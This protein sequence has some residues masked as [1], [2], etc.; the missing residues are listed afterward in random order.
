MIF[1]SVLVRPHQTFTV[2]RVL[3]SG[4]LLSTG[5]L[6]CALSQTPTSV[7]LLHADMQNAPTLP[8]VEE[9]LNLALQQL[10]EVSKSITP[11]ELKSICQR[12]GQ[13]HHTMAHLLV[14]K[15]LES[16]GVALI[17]SYAF[18]LFFTN[19]LFGQQTTL[20]LPEPKLSRWVWETPHTMAKVTPLCAMAKAAPLC[21]VAMAILL[22]DVAVEALLHI[23]GTAMRLFTNLV[24]VVPLE[25]LLSTKDQFLS[26][27]PMIFLTVHPV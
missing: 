7:L 12:L 5:I 26:S 15:T 20:V 17:G 21:A 10:L 23:T 6:C 16:E 3:R 24:A 4:P 14:M 22:H 9:Q 27:T 1:G 8:L 18:S 2:L 11:E 13:M 19:L 25:D